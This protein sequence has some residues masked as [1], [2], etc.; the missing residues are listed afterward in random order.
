MM[1]G[2]RKDIRSIVNW[3]L[4]RNKENSVLEGMFDIEYANHQNVQ[5]ELLLTNFQS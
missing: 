2:Y 5:Y 3:D 1:D 4:C